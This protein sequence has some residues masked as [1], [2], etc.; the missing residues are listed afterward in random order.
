ML[1]L[2]RA[3]FLPDRCI[4]A[5][6]HEDSIMATALSDSTSCRVCSNRS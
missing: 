5:E 4:T 1:W 3:N 6:V 2:G